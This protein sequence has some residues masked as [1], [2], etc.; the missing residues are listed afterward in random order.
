MSDFLLAHARQPEGRLA[1]DFLR[2]YLGPV[3]AR[4]IERHGDWGSLAVALCAHDDDGVLH[5]SHD[6]ISVLCGEPILRAEQMRPG[7]VRGG[8]R[9]ARVAELAARAETDW[10][11]ALDGPF[12]LLTI[13]TAARGA[14]VVTD[15]LAA[16]PA[17]AARHPR[18]HTSMR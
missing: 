4:V 15:L 18:G 16:I 11:H 6:A 14:V 1:V 12:A 13:D 3:T 8:E 2:H 17:S 10:H 9:R 7:V 5:E